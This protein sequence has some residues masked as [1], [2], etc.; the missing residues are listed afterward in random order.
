MRKAKL[1]TNP[2]AITSAIWKRGR[3]MRQMHAGVGSD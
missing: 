1:A 2:L 3:R